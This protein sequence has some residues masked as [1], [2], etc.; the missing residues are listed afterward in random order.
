MTR[1]ASLGLARSAAL[2]ARVALLAQVARFGIQ[3]IGIV[4]LARLLSPD[5][6]GVVAMGAA[7]T[8]L[9]VIVGDFGFSQ[10]VMQAREL[11]NQQ[12][13][14][15][16]WINVSVGAAFTTATLVASGPISGF[17]DDPR[18]ELCLRG[19]AP[20]FL[21]Q[22]LSSQHAAGLARM[23]K[24]RPLAIADVG[25]TALGLALAVLLALVGAGFW[26]L[27]LQQAGTA[28]ARFVI[29][30]TLGKWRPSLPGRAPMASLLSLIHI[31]EPTRRLRGSRMPSSA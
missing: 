21:L 17:Y 27:V 22:S 18:V 14:N 11:S 1:G 7:F 28:L 31:S 9:A 30:F 8:A 25:S 29:L 13:S 20:L 12:A 10:A 2:G 15:L 19:L 26:A 5:D 3:L 24:F 16:F 23:L 6:F 4:W